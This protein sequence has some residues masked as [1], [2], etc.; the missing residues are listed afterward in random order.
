MGC[1]EFLCVQLGGLPIAVA[2]R[3][4]SADVMVRTALARRGSSLPPMYVTSANGEVLSVC[5]R[6]AD[7]RALFAAADIIHADGMPMVWASRLLCRAGLP[8]RVATTD[9][10]HDVAARAE[11]SGATFYLLGAT[12]E[13]VARAERNVR[14]L[15]PG[16]RIVGARHGYVPR[17]EEAEVVDAVNA[18]SPDVLWVSMGVPREQG[19]VVRNLARL[20]GVGVVKTSGGLFDFLSGDKKRAPAWM[21]TAGLEWLYR[22]HLEPRRL[23]TRYALTSPH[24]IFLLITRS[25]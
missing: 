12:A 15:Y 5:S 17:E 9:L 10:F 7:V 6:Q 3:A 25:A 2:D 18:A 24:A 21:Q 8:E 14:R 1:P 22:L 20:T 13:A 4:A 16:L 19:F 23:F 11:A